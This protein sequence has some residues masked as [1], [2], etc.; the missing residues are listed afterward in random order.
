MGPLGGK[1]EKANPLPTMNELLFD[2]YSHPSGPSTKENYNNN[3]NN[4][5][6]NND[7]NNNNYNNNNI[8][9]KIISF[10]NLKL[11]FIDHN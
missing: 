6:N 2:R 11:T 4:N 3:N 8:S 7:N 10:R 9:N 5:N 1:W